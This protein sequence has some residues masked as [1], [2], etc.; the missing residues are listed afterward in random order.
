MGWNWK[1]LKFFVSICWNWLK[2]VEMDWSMLKL[3]RMEIISTLSY[4][5]QLQQTLINFNQF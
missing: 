1:K 5:Y 2:R 4:L 3:E